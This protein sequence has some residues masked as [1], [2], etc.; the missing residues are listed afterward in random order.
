M[1]LKRSAA[2][3]LLAAVLSTGCGAQSKQ[4]T[5][6]NVRQL[7]QKGG[8]LTWSDFD[9]YVCEDIG[10]GMIVLRYPID[11]EYALMIGGPSREQ[12]PMYIRLTRAQV[13]MELRGGDI[14][15]FLARQSD[16]VPD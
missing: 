10:F 14:D 15:S 8:A 7:S 2:I 5:L 1:N 4:L 11:G 3:L 9:R 6:E 12:P 13:A 16:H